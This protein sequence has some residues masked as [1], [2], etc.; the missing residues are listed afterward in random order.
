[1]IVDLALQLVI[2]NDLFLKDAK[3]DVFIQDLQMIDSTCII[4]ILLWKQEILV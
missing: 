1:M 3:N 4:R 2:L